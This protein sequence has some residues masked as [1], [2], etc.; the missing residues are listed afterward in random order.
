[1]GPAEFPLATDPNI[2][3][4]A[5][6]APVAC[7]GVGLDAV[8]VGSANDPRRVWLQDQRSGARI[9]LVWPGGFTVRFG[10]GSSFDVLNASGKVAITSGSHVNGACIGSGGY[11]LEGVTE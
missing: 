1:M 10:P 8:L 9:D 4:V 7:A 11:W 6:A 5:S 3:T 2:S